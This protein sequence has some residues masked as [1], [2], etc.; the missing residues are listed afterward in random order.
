M[1]ALL[2]LVL[3]I[4]TSV[5]HG[6]SQYYLFYGF[7]G[8]GFLLCCYLWF[9]IV[10]HLAGAPRRPW[11]LRLLRRGVRVPVRL[12]GRLATAAVVGL[13]R[14]RRPSPR[15]TYGYMLTAIKE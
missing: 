13:D 2:E 5:A 7:H 3:R 1:I 6:G 11:P 9:V 4:G 12:L 15:F 8:L 10:Y 14:G